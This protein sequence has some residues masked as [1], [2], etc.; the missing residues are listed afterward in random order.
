MKGMNNRTA[1]FFKA[2]AYEKEMVYVPV[3]GNRIATAKIIRPEA[4]VT[5]YKVVGMDWRMNDIRQVV[6][7]MESALDLAT[8]LI[9]ARIKPVVKR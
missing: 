3:N 9:H 5:K 1:Y 7:G 8:K 2:E 6:C 4:D